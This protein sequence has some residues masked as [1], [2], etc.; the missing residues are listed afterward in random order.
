[1]AGED[2]LAGRGPRNEDGV[3]VHPVTPVR[4]VEARDLS[5]ISELAG[6]NNSAFLGTRRRRVETV[7]LDTVAR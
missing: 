6:G 3:R 2:R 1:M 4:N 5:H 7:A